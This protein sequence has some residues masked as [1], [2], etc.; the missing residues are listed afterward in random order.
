MVRKAEL[1]AEAVQLKYQEVQAAVA[2]AE[3]EGVANEAHYKALEAQGAAVQQAQKMLEIT[4]LVADEQRQAA[5][6]VYQGAQETARAAFEQNKVWQATEG[7]ASAAGGFASN[8]S[9]GADAQ[10]VQQR[11]CQTC[12]PWPIASSLAQWPR[13]DQP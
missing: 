7:A 11:Q 6:A 4:T 13:A 2:L 9:Q 10:N 5:E 1:A 12:K 3:A 8:M